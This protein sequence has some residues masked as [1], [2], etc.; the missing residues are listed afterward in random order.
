MPGS[1]KVAAYRHNLPN[2]QIASAG[3]SKSAFQP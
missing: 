2:A 1:F 3:W